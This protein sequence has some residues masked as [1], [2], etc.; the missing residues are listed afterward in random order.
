MNMRK[1]VEAYTPRTD[2]E[3][4]NKNKIQNLDK[5]LEK[6]LLTGENKNT[7][8]KENNK[9]VEKASLHESLLEAECDESRL[10]DP[11]AKSNISGLYQF[12]P[13]SELH[14]KSDWIPESQHYQYY[15]EN[16]DFPINILK[17]K[18]P[19][20][21]PPQLQVYTFDRGDISPFPSPK[22]KSN[23]VSDYYLMDG[24]SILPVLAL[25][26]KLGDKVLDMCSA[27]GGKAL[28]TLQTLLP[29]LLVCNDIQESR[30]NKLRSVMS[31]YIHDYK[32]WGSRL[33]FSQINARNFYEPDTYNK[34]LVDVPCTNDRHNLN[35][36]EN[37]MF[38]S[39]RTKERLK[40]PEVQADILCNALKNIVVGGT[41]IYSTCSLSPIQ[42]DGVVK[43]AL[44]KIWE[45]TNHQ[46]V[47]KDLTN[48]FEPFKSL[49]SFGNGLKY[50]Q[51]VIP[52]LPLNYGP[53]YLC[54]LV[55]VK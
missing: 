40:L 4:P 43:M 28:A 33:V 54:K 15:E 11:E 25:D 9:Y 49:Y 16:P 8:E 41:V 1:V 53:L 55:R 12:I 26:L 32:S 45:E 27:P 6:L 46:I 7:D 42:N 39:T 21:I 34:I 48:Q 44:K 19:L 3:S 36:N 24:G 2:Q 37:N 18:Q 50:G 10:I 30:I 17:E 31:E 14:G 51:L 38:K 5:Q 35:I 20:K 13:T 29:E 22:T 52:F 23:N 47:V